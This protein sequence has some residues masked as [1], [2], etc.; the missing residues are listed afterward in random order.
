MAKEK[1]EIIES[2]QY[3]SAST[4]FCHMLILM[5]PVIGLI[6]GIITYRKANDQE[7][8][9]ICISMLAVRLAGMMIYLLF[10]AFLLKVTMRVIAL[11]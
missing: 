6:Y 2:G 11:F 7:L 9:S 5:L 10:F 3:R 4:M 1:K 8:R